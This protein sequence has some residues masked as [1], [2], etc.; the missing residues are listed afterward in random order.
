MPCEE[1]ILTTLSW[2]VVITQ[3]S[4]RHLYTLTSVSQPR[5][6]ALILRAKS[7]ERRRCN[8]HT[9]DQPLST[10][11]CLSNVIDPKD[12]Y[13]NKNRYVVASQEEDVR[14]HCRNIKGVP[15]VYVK[16]SVMVMEP[17]ADSSLGVREGFEK[18]KFRAGIRGKGFGSGQKRKR[19]EDDSG[20]DHDGKVGSSP[21]LQGDVTTDGLVVKK[22]KIKGPKGPNP[23]SVKKPRK[24]KEAEKTPD[25]A[26]H[27]SNV[28]LGGK[29]EEKE[30]PAAA[31]MDICQAAEGENNSQIVKR[32]RK[33]KHKAGKLV[34]LL[35]VD[36]GRE[37]SR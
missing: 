15:L 35:Q 4:I 33:R 20:V 16:R 9:L 37:D 17:M 34:E 10:L 28:S 7:M 29:K 27:T 30:D 24:M 1:Q 2:T 19:E 6:E 12:S 21:N 32:K 26:D 31:A 14:R 11:E 25:T 13:T 18:G 23:L 5:K 36:V 22:R 8:H 3:C